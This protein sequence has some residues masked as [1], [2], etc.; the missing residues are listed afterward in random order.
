MKIKT[1]SLVLVI[2]FLPFVLNA[3]EKGFT[4]YDLYETL[5][6]MGNEKTAKEFIETTEAKGYVV[7]FV[8]GLRMM[9]HSLY[10]SVFPKESL[11]DSER[12]KMSKSI[13]FKLINLPQDYMISG[14]IELIYKKWAMN[15]PEKLNNTARVCLFVSLIETFGWK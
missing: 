7:G 6:L 15:N 4:G 5:Q 14:Q 10:E 2:I 9:Q 13:N 11:T 8:E 3:S 1:S 12:S